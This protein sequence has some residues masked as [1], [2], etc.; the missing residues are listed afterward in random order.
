MIRKRMIVI[1]VLAVI[2]LVV[3]VKSV[4]FFSLPN[5]EEGVIY[6]NHKYEFMMSERY[7][8][9]LS[10]EDIKPKTAIGRFDDAIIYTIQNDPDV[11]YLYPRVFLLHENYNLLCRVDGRP[12][13]DDISNIGYMDLYVKNETHG[14]D[15]A[16]YTKL[17]VTKE[18][19]S[20]MIDAFQKHVILTNDWKEKDGSEIGILTIHFCQPNGFYYKTGIYKYG[21]NYGLLL[22]DEKTLIKVF[23]SVPWCRGNG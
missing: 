21:D 7:G 13:P 8:Y 20:T 18:L 14:E 1:S 15:E 22:D 3:I 17:E 4:H 9:S 19:E 11:F 6:Q 5:M 10:K 16:A 23:D 2:L 12:S